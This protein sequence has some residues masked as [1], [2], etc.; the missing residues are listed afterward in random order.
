MRKYTQKYTNTV[1][2]FVI[3]YKMLELNIPIQESKNSLCRTYY[4]LVVLSE[5]QY[6]YKLIFYDVYHFH[7]HV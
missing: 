5:E 7:G 3:D 2:V 1:G 6:E 4:L